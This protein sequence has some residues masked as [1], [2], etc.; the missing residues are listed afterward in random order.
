MVDLK[1]PTTQENY[2]R[3]RNSI[4]S[5]LNQDVPEN[6]VAFVNA[7]SFAA[8]ALVTGLYKVLVRGA[9]QNL[10][11]TATGTDLSTLGKNFEVPRKGGTPYSFRCTVPSNGTDTVPPGSRW[12]GDSNG[13][14]YVVTASTADAPSLTTTFDCNAVISGTPGLL[15]VSDLLSPTVTHP[16]ITGAKAQVSSILVEG[17]NQEE[18]EEYRT[19]VLA[20]ERST[21]GGV[22]SY[23]I[24]RWGEAVDGVS[25]IYPY[26]G[27]IESGIPVVPGDRT[28]FVESS[29]DPNG[30]A[31]DALLDDVRTA[32]FT[33][34]ETGLSRHTMGL[35]EETTLVKSITRTSI[36]ITV[37]GV[38]DI[39][40]DS[41]TAAKLEIENEMDLYFRAMFPYIDGLDVGIDRND[42]VTKLSIARQIQDILMSYGGY[43]TNI[44][45]GISRGSSLNSYKMD[46]GEKLKK[47]E[48]I[49]SDA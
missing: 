45:F 37:F 21:G 32:L 26:S 42:T 47:A 1:I 5:K 15:N 19:R 3:C 11:I 10:A 14:T 35:S 12:T 25:G 8:S 43:A 40:S 30:Y 24:R 31:D 23:D 36:Y 29:S 22:N 27:W 49:W 44:E 28:V 17:V 13:Q 38:A 7:L 6:D 18:Q 34:P 41:L 16:G 39:S 33:D 2:D 46:K 9:K 20:A 4:Q 48:V